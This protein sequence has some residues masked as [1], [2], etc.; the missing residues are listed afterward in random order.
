MG[1]RVGR[2]RRREPICRHD[3][4]DLG[5]G[6]VAAD[7]VALHAPPYRAAGY[8]GLRSAP[9]NSP[10]IASSSGGRVGAISTSGLACTPSG[11]RLYRSP[12]RS[13]LVSH[14]AQGRGVLCESEYLPPRS[15]SPSPPPC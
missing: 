7:R 15:G 1:R 13:T 9:A 2:L 10:R 3:R 4:L 14:P 8:G 5:Q 12:P 11:S 6:L